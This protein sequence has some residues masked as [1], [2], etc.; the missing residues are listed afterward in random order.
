M[1][2]GGAPGSGGVSWILMCRLPTV[3]FLFFSMIG[4]EMVMGLVLVVKVCVGRI[5]MV[6]RSACCRLENPAREARGR[7]RGRQT[8]TC[9]IGD[10]RGFTD[11]ATAAHLDQINVDRIS[12]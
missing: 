8:I 1:W 10:T 11:D 5:A 6:V 9:I 7:S 3:F 4:G 2:V 12:T